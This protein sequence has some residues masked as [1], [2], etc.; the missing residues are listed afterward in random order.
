VLDPVGFD[1]SLR[2]TIEH[3]GNY[4]NDLDGFFLERPDFFSS[5]AFWYQTG[6]PKAFGGLPP[7]NERRVPW[8]QQHMVRAFLKA[9]SMGSAKVEVQTEG[10]FGA[11]P[12]LSWPNKEIGARLT[13]PLTVDDD[14]R[15]V[16]RVT[17]AQGPQYG[18]YAIL[19]DGQVA[20][21]GDFRAKEEDELDLSL[22][23]R[24][25]SKGL[26]TLTFQAIG[27]RAEDG[28]LVAKPMAIEMLRLLKL[29]PP[30]ARKIKN[31]NE[32][33]FVRL[34]IGR[35]LYAYRLAYGKLPDSLET[36]VSSGI[37]PKRYL[38]DENG[39]PLKFWREGEYFVVQ[40]EGAQDNRWGFGDS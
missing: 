39:L 14:G 16:L 29:P 37:M 18:R 13:V 40:S 20:G 12:M 24:V 21:E 23:T 11:R 30:G 6:E 5:V 7:W 25:L 8:Q 19:L 22:G 10:L 15:Y 32:A 38:N 35:S 33:H 28:T 2:L 1:K 26:H 17:A 9:R 27:D 36:L 34:G 3:K 31:Q 4:E